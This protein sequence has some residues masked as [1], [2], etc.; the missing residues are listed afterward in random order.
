MCAAVAQS[1]VRNSPV[2]IA[3]GVPGENTPLRP[4]K[5][6]HAFLWQQGH[7]ADLGT[8]RGDSYSLGCGTEEYHT[9]TTA[10]GCGRQ[11]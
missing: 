2:R 7:I 9:S 4:G 6:F 10:H 8:L 3:G 5:S 1:A 11:A